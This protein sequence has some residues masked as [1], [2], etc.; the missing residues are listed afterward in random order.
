MIVRWSRVLLASVLSWF[1][2]VRIASLEESIPPEVWA[3][4]M[5]QAESQCPEGPLMKSLLLHRS[6]GLSAGV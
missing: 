1:E 4:Q 2:G 3:H 6:N 5:L